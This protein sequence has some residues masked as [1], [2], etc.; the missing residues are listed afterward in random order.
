MVFNV[1]LGCL[2]AGF[3]FT[4][5]MVLMGNVFG[6]DGHVEGSH[7]SVEA[8]A[9][10]SDAPGVSAFSPTIIAAFVTAFGG[11]GVIFSEIP[12]TKNPA[13]STPLSLAGA[14]VIAGILVSIMNWLIKHA[15]GS[16]ESH[17]GSLVG[18][19][20]TIISPIPDNGVG[21]IAYVQGGT[22]YSAPAREINGKPIASGQPVQI[23]KIVGSQFFVA[24]LI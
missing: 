10:G 20:G 24:A 21:E 3:F 23:V 12:A 9:D 14:V 6:H 17:V 7:G 19:N 2:V 8:G 5:M 15:Q 22:R 1:Y 11:L 16:S 18:I 13:I 4:L